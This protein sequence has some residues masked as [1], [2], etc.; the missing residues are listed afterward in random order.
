MSRKYV[1]ACDGEFEIFV[2][3]EDARNQIASL[4]RGALSPQLFQEVEF[5][6]SVLVRVAGHDIS[7]GSTPPTNGVKS[8]EKVSLAFQVI[9]S[10]GAAPGQRAEELKA[11]L[12]A[13][14]SELG[15]VLRSMVDAGSIKKRGKAR[16]TKYY[17]VGS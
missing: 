10:L 9:Q 2:D 3:L 5:S 6:T 14:S 17:P 12:G 7:T 11:A 1:V 15:P 13:E 8:E 4:V 16:A